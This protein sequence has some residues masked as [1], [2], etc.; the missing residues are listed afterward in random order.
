LGAT[1]LLTAIA[2]G[3]WLIGQRRGAAPVVRDP[4][5]VALYRRGV[6]EYD[7]RTPAG[8]GN[9][10]QL[11]TAAVRRD[12]TYAAAWAGLAKTYIRAYER[13]FVFPG[14][15]RDSV[16]RLA[17]T[18]VDRALA[19]DRR[20]A[21]A[22]VAQAIVSRS[23]DPTDLTPA[24][25]SLRQALALDS[26]KAPAWHYLAISLAESGDM[27]GAL[28]DWR[29]SVAA[30]P[31]YTEG[32]AFLALGHYW[33]RQYDSA[34][35]WADSAVALEP[36]YLLAR[37]AAGSIAVERGDFARG[38]AAFEAAGRLSTDVELVN[39]LAGSG[40]AEARAGASR[41]ARDVLQ[42]AESLAIVYSPV[43]LHTSVFLA[44]A[45]AALGD[46]DHAI[47]WLQ[48]YT[49]TQDLHFQLH[50][51]CDPP[52]AAIEGEPRFR[53]LLVVPRP[54]PSRGC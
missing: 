10:V 30:D 19:A 54:S 14:V 22:W 47:A 11:F 8:T 34:A 27:D 31:S 24:I 44:Q 17:V 25:R 5:A 32:L 20:S 37:T 49:P 42:R 38:R 2:L 3:A 35:R 50:L 9:A 46:A 39:S 45:Y 51:R 48:R 16:L 4:E 40:L 13:Q 15:A 41:E 53:S 43:P 23:V 28:Q 36:T 18:A 52:Y 6:H 7:Q 1:T 21:D 33:R 26:S 29:R 12:S